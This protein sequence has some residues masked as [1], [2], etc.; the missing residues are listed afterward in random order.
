MESAIFQ[1]K[2]NAYTKEQTKMFDRGLCEHLSE[3]DQGNVTKFD[4]SSI[5]FF[6]EYLNN[7]LLDNSNCW[8]RIFFE[9]NERK[10]FSIIFA[11]YENGEMYAD[12]I[13]QC[14]TEEEA[15]DVMRLLVDSKIEERGFF[16]ETFITKRKGYWKYNSGD[17]V[18]LYRIQEDC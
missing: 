4:I 16:N 1:F 10:R 14:S 3:V 8:F 11:R 18:Y 17:A 7:S 2:S 6:E 13:A 15:L 9:E 12:N 5:N